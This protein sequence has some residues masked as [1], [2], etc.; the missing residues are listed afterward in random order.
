MSR[1]KSFAFIAA[2]LSLC[3]PHANAGWLG[4]PSNYDQCITESMKGITSDVAARAVL[5]SC[6]KQFPEPTSSISPLPPDALR[7]VTGRAGLRDGMAHVRDAFGKMGA[8]SYINEFGGDIYNGTPD[9]TL[10]SVD[11]VVEWTD[12]GKNQQ[13]TFRAVVDIPPLTEKPF[14]VEANVGS[15]DEIKQTNWHIS[16]A[17]GVRSK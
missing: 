4:G 7:A 2:V 9:W 3:C 6:R 17:Q 16:G 10:K 8:K 5:Q 11:V 1:A 12:Q 13:R 14:E 15:A